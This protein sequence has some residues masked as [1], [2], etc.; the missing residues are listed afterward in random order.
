MPFALP[1]SVSRLQKQFEAL[2]MGQVSS[3]PLRRAEGSPLALGWSPRRSLGHSSL[4]AG[5]CCAP[6]PGESCGREGLLPAGWAASTTQGQ[7]HGGGVRDGRPAAWHRAWA[8]TG[9]QVGQR[10]LEWRG[11]WLPC[12][13]VS[14]FCTDDFLLSQIGPQRCWAAVRAHCSNEVVLLVRFPFEMSVPTHQK[15]DLWDTGITP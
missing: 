10:S 3:D 11:T 12:G 2:L 8:V 7:P 13:G 4:P 15:R 6:V 14:V 1:P 5:C 9:S